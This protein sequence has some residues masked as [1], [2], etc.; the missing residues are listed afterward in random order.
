MKKLVLLGDSIRLI[1]YGQRVAELLSDEFETWQPD[2]NC[3]FAAFTL[4]VCFDCQE[5][6][7]QADVIHYN[8]GLWDMCD[9]FGDGAFTPMED[10]VKLM[11]RITHVLRLLAPQATLVFATTTPTS[12]KMWGHDIE[13]IKAYNTAVVKALSEMGVLIDDLFTPVAADIDAMICEDLIH[14]SEQG[15]EVLARQVADF[16]RAI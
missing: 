13:R 3:R 5:E 4:R 6:L 15:R 8:C 11:V 16:V 10:Y 12:P 9:L 7:K 14:L 1:G 2:A